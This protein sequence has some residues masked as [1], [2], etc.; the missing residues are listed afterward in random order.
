MTALISV[1]P[2]WIA[3]TTLEIGAILAAL[4]VVVWLVCYLLRVPLDRHYYP[5]HPELLDDHADD[6]PDQPN[7]PF[8][9]DEAPELDEDTVTTEDTGRH[10]AVPPESPAEMTLYGGFTSAGG[11]L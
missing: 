7:E 3:L 8:P 1:T 10:S 11:A 2:G 6:V 9:A 4:R 5:E